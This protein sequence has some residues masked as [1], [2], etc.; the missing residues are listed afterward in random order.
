[1]SNSYDIHFWDVGQANPRLVQGFFSPLD[2]DNLLYLRQNKTPLT[3][4]KNSPRWSRN[5]NASTP[6]SGSRSGRGS[7]CSSRYYIGRFGGRFEWRIFGAPGTSGISAGG[8]RIRPTK[9]R[10][11]ACCA[12]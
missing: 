6:S 10:S 1:M 8:R 3:S 7:I 11:I 9:K 2:L 5:T 4:N 12:I